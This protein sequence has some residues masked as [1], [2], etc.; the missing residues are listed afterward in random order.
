MDRETTPTPQLEQVGDLYTVAYLEGRDK[1]GLDLSEA[2][3]AQLDELNDRLAGDSHHGKRRHRRQ[4]VTLPAI[5][6][7]RGRNAP[8]L[9]LNMSAGGFLF[10][11][12]QALKVGDHLQ[13]KLGSPEVEYYFPCEVRRVSNFSGT[14]HVAVS[15]SSLPLKIRHG[16][17][18]VA[19][20]GMLTS[21]ATGY[22]GC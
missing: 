1:A 4:D 13:L 6:K 5:L 9:V 10:S 3:R 22:A 17:S 21:H 19:R 8:A 18:K 16:D 14:S 7:Q 2:D 20:L 11:T 15:C 12:T